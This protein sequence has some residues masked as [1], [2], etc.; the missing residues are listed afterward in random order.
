MVQRNG[1]ISHTLG[2]EDTSI[3]MVILPKEIYQ[4]THDIFR[5]TRTSNP[6]FSME[7]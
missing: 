2:L 3:K 5:R 4:I 7:A 1:R 6:N